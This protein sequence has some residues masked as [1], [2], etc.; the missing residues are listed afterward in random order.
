MKSSIAAEAVTAVSAASVTVA[1]VSVGISAA[2]RMKQH[3]SSI[4]EPGRTYLE[5]NEIS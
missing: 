3:L 4:S 5:E 2:D 1:A